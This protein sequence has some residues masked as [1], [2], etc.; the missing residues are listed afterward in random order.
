[1]KVAEL[2]AALAG[3]DDDSDVVLDDNDFGLRDLHEVYG[4]LDN[5]K[6][7]VIL[8]WNDTEGL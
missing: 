8:S 5:G 1:M 4:E 7:R 2:K 6:V 3:F